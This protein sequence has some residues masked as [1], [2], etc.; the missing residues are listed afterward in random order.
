MP[1]ASSDAHYRFGQR[2]LL[3]LDFEVPCGSLQLVPGEFLEQLF[4]MMGLLLLSHHIWS[5]SSQLLQRNGKLEHSGEGQDLE[6]IS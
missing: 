2:L 3:G 6:T 1:P 5:R 4:N